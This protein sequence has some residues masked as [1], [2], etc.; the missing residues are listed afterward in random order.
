MKRTSAQ[1]YRLPAVVYGAPLP[2]TMFNYRI[3]Y[4]VGES[5]AAGRGCVDSDGF[6]WLLGSA[7]AEIVEGLTQLSGARKWSASGA[8]RIARP[9]VR[10]GLTH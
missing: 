8:R 4:R 7:G 6:D 5:R 2:G 3:Y 1:R 9:P 10:A